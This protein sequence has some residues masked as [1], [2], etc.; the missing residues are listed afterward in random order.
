VLQ[1]TAFASPSLVQELGPRLAELDGVRDLVVTPTL[2][3]NRVRLEA[4]VEPFSTEL[5]LGVLRVAGLT[6]HDVSMS[7]TAS[8]WPLAAQQDAPVFNED[9]G[10]AEVLADARRDA[11][12]Y[13][14]YLLNMAA[15]GVIAGV[16]VLTGSSILVV[17]AMAI[18][19]DLLPMSAA[20][21]G[22]V[23][24]RW[25]LASRSSLA[26]LVGLAVGALASAGA[27]LV[28]RLS[29]R[30]DPNLV[31]ADSVLGTSLTTLGPGTVLV[32]LAA[33]VAGML[34]FERAGRA[35]VGV[36]ISVTTIPAA[37]Y[38]GIAAALGRSE[39]VGGA[40]VVLLTNV[41]FVLLASTATL[42]LRRR[43]R[44]RSQ[45]PAA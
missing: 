19:P 34:A 38:I 4:Q 42:T 3:A 22:I 44:S 27:T 25:S 16:G 32:A 41:L 26:L 14:V 15:A 21:V 31:L 40:V 12:I 10:T 36:A 33:G 9:R 6:P 7:R 18:S 39:P 35:A 28:L 17:G 11:R 24:R 45:T 1:L 2:Q 30:L 43:S 13:G 20:T 29:G 5:V 23:E 8:F 37:A